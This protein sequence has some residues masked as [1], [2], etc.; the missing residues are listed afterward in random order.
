MVDNKDNNSLEEIYSEWQNNPQFRQDFKKNPEKALN[1]YNLKLSPADLLKIQTMLNI[2]Q[3]KKPNED[4]ELEGR[5][6]K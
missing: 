6:N 2:K 4:D 1:D 3:L 5:I